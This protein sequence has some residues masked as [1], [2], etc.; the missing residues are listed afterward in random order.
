MKNKARHILEY[1]IKKLDEESQPP[2]KGSWKEQIEKQTEPDDEGALKQTYIY[3][4]VIMNGQQATDDAIG[5]ILVGESVLTPSLINK[6]WQFWKQL[7]VTDKEKEAIESAFIGWSNDKVS[8]L[9]S[10]RAT[11]DKLPDTDLRSQ[12]NFMATVLD[13]NSSCGQK[14]SHDLKMI[15][16][17]AD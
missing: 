10:L 14:L 6:G 5:R 17:N 15:L 12:V 1:V 4:N 13:I 8:K 2:Q 16:A 9:D 7:P 3:L 11:Y